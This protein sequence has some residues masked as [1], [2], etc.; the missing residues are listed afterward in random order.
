[1]SIGVFFVIQP[2]IERKYEEVEQLEWNEKGKRTINGAASK[3]EWST[4]DFFWYHMEEWDYD[5]YKLL[6]L[7]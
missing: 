2:S 5:M 4:S 7:T 3:K 6:K 1:M